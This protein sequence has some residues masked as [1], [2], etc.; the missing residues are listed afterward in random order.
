MTTK[1]LDTALKAVRARR[2]KL[3]LVRGICV[4]TVGLLLGMGVIAALDRWLIMSDDVR[5]V[6]SVAVYAAVGILVWVTSLRFFFQRLRDVDVAG[7]VEERDP[8]HHESIISAVE[9]EKA[10]KDG[11]S[12]QFRQLAK[13]SAEAQLEAHPSGVLPWSMIVRWMAGAILVLLLM[14]SLLFMPGLH[15]DKLMARAFL[16]TANIERPSS[17]MLS[18]LEPASELGY[19][20]TGEEAEVLAMS[21]SRSTKRMWLERRSEDGEVERVEMQRARDGKFSLSLTWKDGLNRIRLRSRSAITRYFEFTGAERPAVVEFRKT[22]HYPEYSRREPLTVEA[23]IGGELSAIEGSEAEVRF[24]LNQDVESMEVRLLRLGEDVSEVVEIKDG[25]TKIPVSSDFDRYH[26]ALTGKETG[27]ENIYRP[28]FEIRARPDLPPVIEL[29]EPASSLEVQPDERV[30]MAGFASDDVGL[31]RMARAYRI[32]DGEWEEDVLRQPE[33]VLLE[34]PLRLE[35]PLA[36]L[37]LKSGETLAV[38][39]VAVDLK[40]QR[41]ESRTLRLEVHDDENA[42]ERQEWAAKERKFAKEM[43]SLFEQLDETQKSMH[44]ASEAAKKEPAERSPTEQ[45]KIARAAAEAASAKQLA[46]NAITKAR[47][48]MVEAPTSVERREAEAVAERLNALK[49][50]SLDPAAEAARRQTSAARNDETE[51]RLTSVEAKARQAA[52]EA[53]KLSEAVSALAAEDVA[54]VVAEEAASLAKRAEAQVESDATGEVL[55]A[56]K[57]MLEDRSESV[58]ASTEALKPFLRP[59][60]QKQLTKKAEELKNAVGEPEENK[61]P[62]GPEEVERKA[63][64]L[65][66]ALDRISEQTKSEAAK[67]REDLFKNTPDVASEMAKLA[68]AA[69][70]V[71]QKEKQ[72]EEL[73]NPSAE[74]AAT[75][76][77]EITARKDELARNLDALADEVRGKSEQ[78]AIPESGRDGAAV[79]NEAAQAMEALED[80]VRE[81]SGEEEATTTAEQLAALGEAVGNLEAAADAESLGRALDELQRMENAEAEESVEEES[82]SLHAAAKAEMESLREQMQRTAASDELRKS[83]QQLAQSN[84]AKQV[85]QEMS[86]RESNASREHRDVSKPLE[87]LQEKVASMEEAL[88]PMAEE[89]AQTIADLAPSISE[90][91]R[92]LAEEMS[93]QSDEL[94]SLA[95]NN[96]GPPDGETAADLASELYENREEAEEIQS[97]LVAEA[98]RQDLRD[99]ESRE[100]ARDADDALAQM[101]N[102]PVDVPAERIEEAMQSATSPAEQQ[103]ELNQAAR[104]Q[105]RMAESLTALA[106]Q[107]ENSGSGEGDSQ[108]AR[109]ALRE[110]E[111]ESGVEQT[112]DSDYG[113]AQELAN[114]LGEAAENPNALMEA[115]E[116]EL[117][118][119]ESMQAALESL[120]A[121]TAADAAD[122]LAEAA[123]T[124]GQLKQAVPPQK[125]ATPAQANQQAGVR[126]DVREAGESLERAGRHQ[127]RLGN[128]S[129][130]QAMAEAGSLTGAVAAGEAQAAQNAMAKEAPNA[131]QA[132]ELLGVAEEAVQERAAAAEALAR[133]AMSAASSNSTG[134]HPQALQMAM[135]LDALDQQMASSPE[136]GTPANEATQNALSRAM[137]QQEMGMTKSRTLGFPG[138]PGQSNSPPQDGSEEPGTMPSVAD[139]ERGADLEEFGHGMAGLVTE[140]TMADGDADWSKLPKKVAEDILSGREQEMSPDYRYAIESYFKAI[141]QETKKE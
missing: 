71:A 114:M 69:R 113:D 101:Q 132:S 43:K 124:E 64:E 5:L 104:A 44:E 20:V 125:S 140:V 121:S 52:G 37:R 120:A 90:Q 126:S 139:G 79:L 34:S 135:A 53:R 54:E 127:E 81:G 47:E 13:E 7:A 93:E 128:E 19:V 75:L 46:E 31:A 9:L 82:P 25:V 48:L 23:E 30:V 12:E 51:R 26:V 32:G 61:D 100:A 1:R 78:A 39:L 67:A 123:A 95:Q 119:N 40:G 29:T 103:H 85:A 88:Q 50:R 134:F 84:E 15:L 87:S 102:L 2:R 56:E 24:T 89:A 74:Q 130:A 138:E 92:N 105:Q 70:T 10:K 112:L 133:E 122:T 45:Q 59:N 110:S 49:E 21:D 42:R 17:V 14:G 16:P 77:R 91:M 6:L 41:A 109:M 55:D 141:A 36:P 98:N 11:F 137:E 108:E 4:A 83:A 33:G 65:A 117:A 99:A 116:A 106:D 76:D 62:A 96:G 129:A 80:R 97:A 72:R 118:R 8:S 35:W 107:L 94:N 28:D 111:E 136:G 60:E 131:G 68:S 3:I 38:K 22:Y 73:N 66:D 58:L 27:F 115:L 57:E 86:Q 18:L 63:G